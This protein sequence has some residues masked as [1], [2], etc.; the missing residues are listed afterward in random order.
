MGPWEPVEGP[1]S[2]NWL[3]RAGQMDRFITEQALTPFH[4]HCFALFSSF[5]AHG[6]IKIPTPL[7]KN[8]I[9]PASG[10]LTCS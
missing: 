1:E 9:S 2:G 8:H 7:G 5:L 10:A 6:L 3:E 4:S